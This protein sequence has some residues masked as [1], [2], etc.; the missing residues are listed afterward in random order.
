MRTDFCGQ[1]SYSSIDSPDEM[2]LSIV[3]MYVYIVLAVSV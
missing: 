2:A 1:R 3:F